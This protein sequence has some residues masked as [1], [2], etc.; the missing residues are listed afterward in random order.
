[1][2][3]LL[4]A[5]SGD[6]YQIC[7]VFRAGEAGRLHNPEFTL[8][9]WYRIGFDHFQLMDEV[10]AL[11]RVLL[12]E[13]APISEKIT[14][15]EAFER[16]AGFDPFTADAARFMECLDASGIVLDANNWSAGD[17]SDLVAGEIVYPRLGHAGLCFV[18]DYPASQAALAQ[19]RE[20]PPAVAE[21]FELFYRGMELANGFHELTDAGEQRHRFQVDIADRRMRGRPQAP[22]D[23]RLL[24]ALEYGLPDC[25]GVALGFDRVAMLAANADSLAE[26]LA[27]PADR[28]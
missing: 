9:E 21:R 1:M 19:V 3:R 16:H 20:G 22:I 23:T 2:K 26:V 18:Y 12:P 28:A 14:Y 15:R 8:A 4:A 5:G 11:M 6:I 25:A 10:E 13:L 17:L 24:A 7:K 27:F